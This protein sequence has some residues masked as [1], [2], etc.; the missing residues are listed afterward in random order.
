MSR[1]HLSGDGG[2]AGRTSTAQG[3]SHPYCGDGVDA[4]SEASFVLSELHAFALSY[5]LLGL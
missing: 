3:N 4:A 2:E 5:L 1:K